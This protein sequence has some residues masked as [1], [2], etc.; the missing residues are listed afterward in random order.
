MIALVLIKGSDTV[1]AMKSHSIFPHQQGQEY[2][3]H[4]LSF[5]YNVRCNPVF[6]WRRKT[7]HYLII[8]PTSQTQTHILLGYDCILCDILV[9][10]WFI[11]AQHFSN[12]MSSSFRC[13]TTV[14]V[15]TLTIS[16]HSTS[17]HHVTANSTRQCILTGISDLTSHL[18]VR[19]L[20]SSTIHSLLCLPCCVFLI[21]LASCLITFLAPQFSQDF[22]LVKPRTHTQ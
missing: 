4:I 18:K 11:S 20:F 14:I 21:A 17:V 7:L 3:K 19:L 22:D 2:P 16:P 6:N 9:S 13:A 15:R 12:A 10:V 1:M 5:L 8:S